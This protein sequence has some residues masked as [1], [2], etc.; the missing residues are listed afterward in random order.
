[1]ESL[2]KMPFSKK[3]KSTKS[4]ALENKEDFIRL[5]DKLPVGL[6]WV[7]STN[8][9]LWANNSAG[10]ILGQN[11]ELIKKR[12]L[13]DFLPEDSQLEFDSFLTE[14]RKG[15]LSK[16][17]ESYFFFEGKEQIQELE[18]AGD[19]VENG[20]EEIVQL[21]LHDQYSVR[22]ALTIE[23]LRAQTAEET[24]LKLQYEISER[25]KIESHLQS[26]R[27]YKKSLIESSL[28]MI[29]STDLDYSI[30]EFNPAASA[31]FGYKQEEIQGKALAVLF[32]DAKA[33]QEWNRTIQQSGQFVGD[34]NLRRKDG[35]TMDVYLT[36]SQIMVNGKRVGLMGVI[37]DVSE[38]KKRQDE[39]QESEER[40]RVIYNQAFIG[41]ARI[42]KTG[43][44][45][46]VNKRVSSILGYS[47]DE[48]NKK[49]FFELLHP[50]DLKTVL[51]KWDLLSTG[52][53][54]NFEAEQRYLHKKGNELYVKASVSLVRDAKGNPQYFIASY[55]DITERKMAEAQIKESLKEKEVLIKEIHH[56]VKNNLQV[57]SS[58]LNLQT[59]YIEDER[60]IEML[61]DSQNRIKSMSFIHESLY[62]TRNLAQINFTEYIRNLVSNLGQSYNLFKENV[63]IGYQLDEVSL[64]LDTA[65]PLGLIIN[66]LITNSF[67][68]AFSKSGKGTLEVVLKSMDNGNYSLVIADNGIGFPGDINFR[69]TE[70]L[71]LQL[72]T[73]LVQQIQGQIELD[74]QKG[75]I[76]TILFKE[77]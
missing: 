18:I 12:S 31:T 29:V 49:L 13:F 14:I 19:L 76:F 52:Q 22:K 77:N 60:T 54:D 37:R 48:L 62:Q 2:E 70:S 42:A 39:L 15:G 33:F 65:I 47:P 3:T 32:T 51:D 7:N 61:K 9:I 71:G 63:H 30:V 16:T 46:L 69:T 4:S 50:A 25:Q 75:A 68:Y 58:I 36:S 5:V 57:I 17:I 24:N 53:M 66:E 23:Q 45:I 41:I 27:E 21:Q 8:Q 38:Q 73:T 67:K 20:K 40:F 26:E 74:N 1:L 6:I 43:R 64:G 35:S 44:F 72:V 56:R 55:E 10:K 59:N 28:D 11:S 34:L